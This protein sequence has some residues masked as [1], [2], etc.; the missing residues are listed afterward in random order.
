MINKIL[1]DSVWDSCKQK[2][3][4]NLY[5]PQENVIK[6][7]NKTEYKSIFNQ[8]DVD[9]DSFYTLYVTDDEGKGLPIL[10]YRVD[11]IGVNIE[12]EG[13]ISQEIGQE[14]YTKA[15]LDFLKSY[16]RLVKGL[17]TNYIDKVVEKYNIQNG[18]I[19]SSDDLKNI[20]SELY[21]RI[22][23][24]TSEQFK[25]V[26]KSIQNK[27]SKSAFK[28]YTD[29][30]GC[31]KSYNIVIREEQSLSKA[32][33]RIISRSP[34]DPDK[35]KLIIDGEEPP[36]TNRSKKNKLYREIKNFVKIAEKIVRDPIYLDYTISDHGW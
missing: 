2:G 26:L 4:K 16:G 28:K 10:S 29:S 17:S 27:A 34:E 5:N 30:I 24:K 25:L 6:V 31:D 11:N 15:Y 3:F 14:M 9:E 35:L 33:G 19:K 13:E 23:S 32:K 7:D 12:K 36:N 20:S 18:E 21:L 22:P 8:L 1:F